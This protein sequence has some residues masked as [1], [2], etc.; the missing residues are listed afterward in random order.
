MLHVYFIHSGITAIAAYDSVK[1]NLENGDEVCVISSRGFKWSYF[2]DSVQAFDLDELMKGKGEDLNLRKSNFRIIVRQI[3]DWKKYLHALKEI[4]NKTIVRDKDFIAYLPIYI[5]EFVRHPKCKGY[6]FL[7]EGVFA[8]FSREYVTKI[9]RNTF[10]TIFKKCVFPL[11]GEHYYSIDYE[12]KKFLGSVAISDKAFPWHN[13]EHIVRG[14]SGYIKEVSDSALPFHNIIVTDV[15]FEENSV[16]ENCLQNVITYIENNNAGKIGFKMHPMMYT[17]YSEKAEDV[18]Q[19]IGKMKC[20]HDISIL[21]RNYV[22]ENN[23]FKYQ[24][25]IYSI[26]ELSSL[27]LYAICFNAKTYLAKGLK[28]HYVIKELKTVQEFMTEMCKK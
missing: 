23:I 25:N 9:A 8:Y 27:S 4:I 5:D 12:S 2:L 11:F 26:F 7:E 14:V 21:P 22:I 15:L 24:T 10:Q 1:F 6:Y 13:K 16:I 20:L 28:E 3:C 19:I 17:K 18:E